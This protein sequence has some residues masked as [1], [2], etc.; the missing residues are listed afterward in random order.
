MASI[1]DFH[2]VIPAGGAGTRLWPLSRAAHP[3]FLLD[4]TGAGRTLLQQTWDRLAPLTGTEGIGVVTGSK[5]ADAVQ[6]QLP[7]LAPRNLWIEPGP[8]D[9]MAAI[10]L[11]A[12]LLAHR[13]GP[14][15]IL[16]SFAAD[17]VIGDQEEFA[18]AVR[19]AV[20]TAR[21]G[22]IVTLGMRATHPSTA[23]GYIRA[24][25]ALADATP[26]ARAVAEFVEK[27]DAE[28]AAEYLASGHYFWNAGM[29]IFR[30]G[31]LLEHLARLHP[32]L[33]AGLVEI[34]AAWDTDQRASV[35]E[36][37]WPS[38]T[39]I[40]IDH[41]IA[42]PVAASGGVAVVPAKFAW[43]DVGDWA[44]LRDLIPA[45]GENT[46]LRTGDFPDAPEPIIRD[47]A[48]NLVVP[49][50]GRHVVVLGLTDAV[51]VDTPG[52][53]LVAS[54]EQAQQV[55]EIVDALRAGGSA[56]VL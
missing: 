19:S 36:R 37:V 29:F 32:Q 33:H 53:L 51:V 11:A 7:A 38:L 15:S 31:V 30:T 5:H 56:E 43:D 21:A 23:F 24:G 12:A 39:K 27:P 4:L 49:A 54:R 20:E 25:D 1:P 42:E 6:N 40:A 16:G 2:A 8:R 22:Y 35:L 3:K 45:V 28:T 48:A 44:A 13:V 17:H 41:A 55:K 14:D 34:A 26:A 10:G 52:A 9:S 46:I 47:G 50:A 18:A